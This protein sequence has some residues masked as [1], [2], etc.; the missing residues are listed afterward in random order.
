MATAAVAVLTLTAMCQLS[1]GESFARVQQ[2]ALLPLPAW[3]HLWF[4][5]PQRLAACT[6]Q[7]TAT[8]NWLSG[9]PL[10]WTARS[11]MPLS[12]RSALCIMHVGLSM[13]KT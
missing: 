13:V 1:Q 9:Y 11:P 10:T 12:S 8:A 7:L 2:G 5:Q 3:P 4:V 6:L